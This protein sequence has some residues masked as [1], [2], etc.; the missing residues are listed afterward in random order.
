MGQG[1]DLSPLWISFKIASFAAGISFVVGLAAA[2]WMLTYKGK[3]KPF[4]DGIL[5]LP[6]VLPPTVV[7]YFLLLLLG[8][9]GPL[10]SLLQFFDISIVFTWW[11]GVIAATVVAFPLMYRTALG[12]FEQVDPTFLQAS[13]TLGA[14]EWRVFFKVLLPLSKP[15]VLAGVIFAF[16]RSLG[17]FGATLM[18]AGNI[19]GKTTTIPL[20]IFF[21]SEGGH[22]TQALGWVLVTTGISIV[23]IVALNIWTASQKGKSLDRLLAARLPACLKDGQLPSRSYVQNGSGQGLFVQIQKSLPDFKL[24]LEFQTHCKTLGILGPSGSGKSMLLKCIAG[25][26]KPSQGQIILNGRV[27][28]DSALEVN[29]P[30]RNR[31]VGY[32][33]QSFALFP[34]LNV[35]EN[36]AFGMIAQKPDSF[37]LKKRVSDLLLKLRISHLAERLP[38]QLSGG[39]QQRVALARVLAMEPELIL[40]DE[41]FSALDSSLRTEMQGELIQTLK[42]FNV[43]AL[44]VTHDRSEAKRICAQIIQL[45]QG[46]QVP[47]TPKSLR[48]MI[49]AQQFANDLAPETLS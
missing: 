6:L 34:H 36:V 11:A 12:A 3:L 26:E 45:D 40:L 35:F 32:L 39:Q 37:E 41:P 15:G 23:S 46:V 31:K 4:I 43:S 19:P 38:R 44:L 21:A 17:E 10:G 42:E 28:F 16:L 33:F 22:S 20:A 1:I 47:D 5:T 18:V 13:R 48:S 24:D 25:I 30:P 8:R 27:L 29:I 49:S 7:G 9:F 2:R 14:S